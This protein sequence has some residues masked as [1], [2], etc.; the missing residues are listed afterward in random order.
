MAAWVPEHLREHA[1][2]NAEGCLGI[3]HNALKQRAHSL[4]A[5]LQRNQGA[6]V[7]GESFQFGSERARAASAQA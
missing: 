2:G 1:G 7:E 3:G 4:V 5:T 6:S